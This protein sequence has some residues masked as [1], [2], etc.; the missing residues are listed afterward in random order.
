VRLGAADT[1]A[2]ARPAETAGIKPEPGRID[3]IGGL[4]ERATQPAMRPG[5]HQRQQFAKP[6]ARA[7]RIGIGQGRATRQPRPDVVE[8]R[9]MAVQTGDDLAQ[10]R[11]PGELA[12]EQRHQLAFCRQ[13][14]NPRIA[15]V[16][17]CQPVKLAP[18]QML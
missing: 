13:L 18:R 8:P 15:P 12:I 11:R 5:H 10:A 14:A 17:R 7:P 6:R 16:R 4:G 2:K 1:F 3:Q 9:R